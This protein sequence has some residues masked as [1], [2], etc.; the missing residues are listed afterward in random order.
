MCSECNSVVTWLFHSNLQT[1]IK[2]VYNIFI[3]YMHVFLWDIHGVNDLVFIFGY[4]WYVSIVFFGHLQI[5][6]SVISIL[7]TPRTLV[8]FIR[9][10][11]VLNLLW[12]KLIILH[13]ETLLVFE[14]L[15]FEKD[16]V[17]SCTNCDCGFH[18]SW[19][20]KEAAR[21]R[22]PLSLQ[23]QMKV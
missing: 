7:F 15:I 16:D 14:I 9:K 21:F 23:Y 19:R 4:Q 1:S 12:S 6:N 13:K 22:L 11:P 5:Q 17:K 3:E 18:I 8:S 20:N 10:H 2:R